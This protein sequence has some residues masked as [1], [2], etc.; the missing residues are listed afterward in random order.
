MNVRKNKGFSFVEVMVSVFLVSV[1]LL[2]ALSLL[3]KGLSETMDSRNQLIASLLAQEGVELVRSVRD[4]NWANGR[5]SF[6]GIPNGTY[7]IDYKLTGF[8][9]SKKQL[10]LDSDGFYQ[11]DAGTPTKFFRK[12]DLS[13]P[14]P[15][16]KTVRSIVAWGIAIATQ[17]PSM[18]D[19][20]TAH[21]CAYT[22]DTL[23]KWGE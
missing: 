12:I 7:A 21:K 2:A 5:D 19:C 3:T 16:Q 20:N 6:I 10:K 9:S 13:E 22:E 18:S 14:I 8:D 23:T 4:T 15:N 11:G 17:I 1:G